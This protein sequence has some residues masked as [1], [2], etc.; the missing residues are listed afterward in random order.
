MS[1]RSRLHPLVR[2]APCSD[3][4]PSEFFEFLN[5]RIQTL[6]A[7]NLRK[8]LLF[9]RWSNKATKLR[10]YDRV[11]AGNPIGA[12]AEFNR[13]HE[14]LHALNRYSFRELQRGVLNDSTAL[15]GSQT[16]FRRQ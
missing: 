11:P 14:S 3:T 7:I 10:V 1:Q 8:A 5:Q 13:G 6:F 16:Q 2:T 15:P 12:I 9:R 4:Q